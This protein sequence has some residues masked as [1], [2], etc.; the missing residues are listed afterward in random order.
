MLIVL[1]H[2]SNLE[3]QEIEKYI[4][5]Y[6]S[7]KTNDHQMIICPSSC[8]LPLF[9]QLELGSQDISR[10]QAGSYTGEI[11]GYALKSLNVSYVLINH[12][13]R[14]K[15]LNEGLEIARK[16]I[17][18]AVESNLIPIIC[19]GDTK[20]EH[21][22]RNHLRKIKEILSQLITKELKE[23]IIAYEPLYAI[24]TGIVPSNDDIKE[25][26]SMIKETYH[27]KVL[28]GGSVDEKNV[29]ILKEVDQIDGF[30]LGGISLKLSNLQTLLQ[31]LDK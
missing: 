31:K 23:Y 1:N 14:A 21:E 15:C 3:K 16:K 28:Y 5:E 25:M 18:R 26:I 29:E 8:Y 9:E 11:S 4:A 30:L 27:T 22:Q 13:E 2:K 12:S 20:E 10:Y 19:V 24:G 7:L 6:K 17:E